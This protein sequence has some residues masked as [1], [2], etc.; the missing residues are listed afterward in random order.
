[1]AHGPDTDEL[2]RRISNLSGKTLLGKKSLLLTNLNITS[3]PQ[4][5]N[6]LKNLWCFNTKL[7]ELPLLPTSLQL[8]YCYDT[9]I[10]EL[11]PLPSS[12]ISLSCGDT[13]ITE[14]PPL[15]NSLINIACNHTNITELP[16]LPP[17]LDYLDCSDTNIT[18]LP[19]LPHSLEF[20]IVKN[21]PLVLQRMKGESIQDYSARWDEW[22]VMKRN[23][24][25]CLA[26]KEDLMAAA[27]HP[28][29]V[30]RWIE[31]CGIEVLDCM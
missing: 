24:N 29:R 10:T 4:L 7:T 13:Q 26:V 11:P 21:C 18:E 20:L 9:N 28:R 31:A 1:M 23:Q 17:N 3:M 5:P 25:R 2:L 6:S 30:E 8:L 22:R 15:P 16:P 19:P 14:L 12:L 27:W